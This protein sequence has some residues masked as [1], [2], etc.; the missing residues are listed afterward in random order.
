MEKFQ[1]KSGWLYRR[2]LERE[3]D[4]RINVKGISV[5]PLSSEEIEERFKSI[6]GEVEKK[7]GEIGLQALEKLREN[8]LFGRNRNET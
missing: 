2:L 4:Y 6:A 3:P 1:R 7:F 5:H 8:V